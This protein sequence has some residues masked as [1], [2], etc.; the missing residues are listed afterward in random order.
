LARLSGKVLTL[1][2]L[3]GDR[4]LRCTERPARDMLADAAQRAAA[5]AAANR[6]TISL[7]VDGAAAVA[8]DW[9][10]LAE[11]LDLLLENAVAHSPA[12]GEIV[13]GARCEGGLWEVTVQDSGPGVPAEWRH[14]V[15]DEFSVRDLMH[16]HR[17][18]GLSLAIVR[19][20]AELHGGHVE[21]TEAA[22]GGARFV[23]RIPLGP[24]ADV[25]AAV[26]DRP[27]A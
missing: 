17:G 20:I 3:K 24:T 26:A 13:L 18:S 5:A 22:G 16:H 14:R 27:S 8:A 11:A 21:V 15:F 12:G 1:A 2:D 23:C 6:V 4:A 7:A 25:E 9:S 10:L 19:H